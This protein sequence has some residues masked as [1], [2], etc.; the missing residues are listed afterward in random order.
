MGI[1]HVGSTRPSILWAA[2][3]L[4]ACLAKI[5]RTPTAELAT[6]YRL[7]PSRT[8]TTSRVT[9]QLVFRPLNQLD[10]HGPCDPRNPFAPQPPIGAICGGLGKQ[11]LLD[12]LVTG[13]IISTPL[14]L[15]AVPALGWPAE[16]EVPAP[17]G[18]LDVQA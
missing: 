5:R 6:V 8:V 4:G 11:L 7:I 16:V 14:Q 12:R 17:G 1:Y 2:P 9:A 3:L 10:W 18:Q 15:A 13:G